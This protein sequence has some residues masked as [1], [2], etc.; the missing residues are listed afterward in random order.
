M[1]IVIAAIDG[2]IAGG[3]DLGIKM[4]VPLFKIKALV[5]Q[6]DIQVYSSNYSL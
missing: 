4:G 5:K 3:K 2:E 6:H 1:N